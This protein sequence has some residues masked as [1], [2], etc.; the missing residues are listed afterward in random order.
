MRKS[1]RKLGIEGAC[2]NII[3]AIYDSSTDTIILS[4]K[5]ELISSVVRNERRVSI[6]LLFI[7][8]L[9]G[10]RKENTNRKEEF[11]LSLFADDMILY[12]KDSKYFMNNNNQTS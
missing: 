7:K 6:P 2:L 4:G 10:K 8:M 11:K 3:K 12:L 5:T 1:L 9:E